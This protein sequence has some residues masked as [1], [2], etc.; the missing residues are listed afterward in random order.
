MIQEEIK[1]AERI[2][3]NYSSAFWLRF[4]FSLCMAVSHSQKWPNT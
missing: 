1:E 2:F 3:H 4:M